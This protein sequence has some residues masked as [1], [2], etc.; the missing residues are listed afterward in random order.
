MADRYDVNQLL[1]DS[2]TRISRFSPSQLH[3][4]LAEGILIIDTRAETDR[5][6]EG[7]IPGSIPVPLSVLLWRLDPAAESTNPIL[8]DL[9]EAKVIVCGDGYSS[10]WAAATLAD[11]GFTAV[12]DLDG[13]FHA[14]A[15]QGLPVVPAD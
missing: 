12:S 14:W 15:A 5:Q 6:R 7:T 10:S 9:N 8:N 3:Q 2:R 13:G 4:A 1:A 11:L